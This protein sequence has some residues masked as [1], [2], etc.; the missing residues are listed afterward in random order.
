MFTKSISTL[1]LAFTITLFANAQGIKSQFDINKG[2]VFKIGKSDVHSAVFPRK[3]GGFYSLETS[4]GF[5][6]VKLLLHNFSSDL[7]KLSEHELELDFGDEEHYF[8]GMFY[9]N[10]VLYL[11]SGYRDKDA[12]KHSLYLHTINQEAFRFNSESKVIASISYDGYKK[13][14][15]GSFYT[16]FSSDKSKFLIYQENPAEKDQ[17]ASYSVIVLDLKNNLNEIWSKNY[18]SELDYEL[19]DV[20]QRKVTNEGEVIVLFK[21]FNEK[22]KDKHKGEPNYS[23]EIRH[24]S[25][26]G[27]SLE[28]YPIHLENEYITDMQMGINDNGDI[29]CTGFYSPEYGSSITGCYFLLLDKEN[30]TIKKETKQAFSMD[31]LTDFMKERKV[32]KAKKKKEKGKDLALYNYDLQDIVFRDDGGIIQVAEQAYEVTRTYTD[33]NGNTRSVTT[34][35]YNTLIIISISPEGEIEWSRKIPKYQATSGAGRLWASYYMDVVNNNM[36]FFH[37]GNAKNLLAEDYGDLKGWE[38]GKKSVLVATEI[39]VEGYS[40]KDVIFDAKTDKTIPAPKLI[41][42]NDQDEL[43]VFAKYKKKARYYKIVIKK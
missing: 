2:P 41:V 14:N 29:I 18:Q 11:L 39:N 16:R 9:E 38:L 17:K 22:R 42:K 23:Y 36:Y 40:K 33:A 24:I 4:Y 20:I 12:K 5:G 13:S 37:I 3:D 30:K 15:I 34:Y 19:E 10:E 31:F 43:I 35:Y 21:Q 32:K 8:Q 26:K 28:T 1:I 6:G 27:E 25:D 7:K